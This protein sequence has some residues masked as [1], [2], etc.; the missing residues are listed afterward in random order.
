L[1]VV[2]WMNDKHFIV[3][4]PQYAVK[5]DIKIFI[6]NPCSSIHIYP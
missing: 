1:K 4:I 5:L 3:D 6:S 2:K